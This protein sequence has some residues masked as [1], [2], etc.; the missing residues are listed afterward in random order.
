MDSAG[1]FR[2]L[3]RYFLFIVAGLLV[4]LTAAGVTAAALPRAYTAQSS[5]FLQV[6]L[7]GSTLKS[8]AAF[9]IERVQS[10]PVLLE[11]PVLL[12]RVIDDLS[13]RMTTQQL[14][15]DLKADSPPG[16]SLVTVTARSLCA[17][18][19]LSFRPASGSVHCSSDSTPGAA[20]SSF[21]F[22]C[23][24]VASARSASFTSERSVCVK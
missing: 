15:D 9:A 13:L 19:F 16:T 24:L 22:A 10:Y 4:G 2:V 11:S 3:R 14:A 7:T 18:S 6:S 5:L 12:Q 8:R 17:V 20:L 1:Y 23:T 21:S